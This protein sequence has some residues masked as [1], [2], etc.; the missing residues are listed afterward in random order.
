MLLSH[1]QMIVLFSKLEEL[2]PICQQS[3]S[4]QLEGLLND[5]D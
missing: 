1:L 5:S 2:A 3:M 4:D